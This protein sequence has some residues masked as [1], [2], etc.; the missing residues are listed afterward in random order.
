MIE[1]DGAYIAVLLEH[2]MCARGDTVEQALERLAHVVRIN[3]TLAERKSWPPISE[4]PAASQKWEDLWQDAAPLDQPA[5]VEDL[6][7]VE[8][9]RLHQAA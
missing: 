1:E 4:M 2:L 8:S 7:Q 3:R 6:E 5:E 9:V